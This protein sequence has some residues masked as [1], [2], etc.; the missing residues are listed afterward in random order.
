MIKRF[1]RLERAKRTTPLRVQVVLSD[2]PEST[3]TEAVAKLRESL[4]DDQK[5]EAWVRNCLRLPLGK[6]A[7]AP[8]TREVLAACR[9]RMDACVH[10]HDAAKQEVLRLLCTGDRGHQAFALGFEGAAGV[11]KT[12]FAKAALGAL[13]KPL[14]FIS[15]AGATDASFL[16]G[17]SYTYEGSLPGRVASALQDAGTINVVFYFDELDKISKSTKGEEIVSVLIGLIDREQSMLF[18]DRYFHGVP[19]DLSRC[20]FAF[21]YNNPAD[22]HPILLD[23]IKRIRM[24]TPTAEEKV[25]ITRDYILPRVLAE[26]ALDPASVSVADDALARIVDAYQDQGMRDV[27][28]DLFE[29][30][31]NTCVQRIETG[32]AERVTITARDVERLRAAR[33]P[34]APAAPHALTMYA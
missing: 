12:T 25:S 4:R 22:V 10:R 14:C 31:G 17:H 7:P 34:A 30:V 33:A 21:S 26:L 11:G 32:S 2:L 16:V 23:R 1:A 8:I 19:L 20:T 24:E 13:G 9:A 18:R 5:Y 15:L 27:Q 28:K 3:K 6:C 29:L